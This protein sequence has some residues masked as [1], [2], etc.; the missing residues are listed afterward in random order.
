MLLLSLLLVMFTLACHVYTCTGE[1]RN[2][3]CSFGLQMYDK[4][5]ADEFQEHR[6]ICVEVGSLEAKRFW[7]RFLQDVG[8]HTNIYKNGV[9]K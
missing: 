1:V 8:V 6:L 3:K 5:L 7:Y 2:G 9:N 4:S